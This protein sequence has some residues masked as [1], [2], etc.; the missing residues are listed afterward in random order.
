MMES[1]RKGVAMA[2][3]NRASEHDSTTNPALAVHVSQLVKRYG[4]M[5]A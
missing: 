1:P 4:D 5:V 2:T 3:D